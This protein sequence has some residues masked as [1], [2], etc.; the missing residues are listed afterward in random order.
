MREALSGEM[1][2]ECIDRSIWGIVCRITHFY[3]FQAQLVAY[4]CDIPLFFTRL[5]L[6]SGAMSSIPLRIAAL[7][8]LYFTRL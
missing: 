3:H 1:V 5:L 4:L 8:L 7:R 6:K 2:E